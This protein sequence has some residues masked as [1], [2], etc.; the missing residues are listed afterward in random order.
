M[1]NVYTIKYIHFKICLYNYYN[2]SVYIYTYIYNIYTY[3]CY[4]IL[5][6]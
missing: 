1:Y 5:N 3:M 6:L 4:M 2:M